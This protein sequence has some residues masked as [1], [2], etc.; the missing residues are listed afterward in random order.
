MFVSTDRDIFTDHYS[1]K[2]KARRI[3]NVTCGVESMVGNLP[4]WG[5]KHLYMACLDPHLTYGCEVTLD[6]EPSQLR[7]LQV[8]QHSFI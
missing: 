3:V 2:L 5:C 8:V 4:P 6:V 1:I 7:E